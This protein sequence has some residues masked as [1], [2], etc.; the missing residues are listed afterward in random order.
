MLDRAEPTTGGIRVRVSGWLASGSQS[1]RY[2]RTGKGVEEGSS[3]VETRLGRTGPASTSQWR[4]RLTS[5][6]TINPHVAKYVLCVRTMHAAS[7]IEH[8]TL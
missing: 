7:L 1:G 3:R 2:V 8:H 5:Y 4:V 6:T